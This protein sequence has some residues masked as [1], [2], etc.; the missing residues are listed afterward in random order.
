MKYILAAIA[1]LLS[2][3]GEAFARQNNHGPEI[4]AASAMISPAV[5]QQ[6]LSLAKAKFPD[7]RPRTKWTATSDGITMW[8]NQGRLIV[9]WG[10]RIVLFDEGFLHSD[11]T[12]LGHWE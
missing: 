2:L 12:I 7:F 11:E 6:A 8:S 10:G 3:S 1:I 5:L 9:E 4:A